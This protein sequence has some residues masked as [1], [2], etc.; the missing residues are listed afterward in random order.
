MKK[1][2]LALAVVFAF[3]ATA[4]PNTCWDLGLPSHTVVNFQ[5]HG[6]F[7]Q[8]PGPN[9]DPATGLPLPLTIGTELYGV[10]KIDNIVRVSDLQLLFTPPAGKEMTLSFWDAI[11]A[12]SNQILVP[13]GIGGTLDII[14]STF[15]DG[16]R[17]QIMTDDSADYK[18]TGGPSLFNQATGF[19]PTVDTLGADPGET[20]FLDLVL[21][22]GSSTLT[23]DSK[24]GFLSASF[25][26]NEVNILGGC[27]ADQFANAVKGHGDVLTLSF[28]PNWLYNAN[29]NVLM[30][31]VPAPAALISLVSGLALV[32]GSRL[33]RKA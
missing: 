5:G 4:L 28:G 7:D 31:T 27:G 8:N 23:Y 20:L 3:T 16:A 2:F 33:R 29:T 9:V 12:T 32:G 24:L 1:L 10:A 13:D 15:N 14:N 6:A 26:S 17:I 30:T 21:N 18:I 11:V 19:Y 22:E 25:N